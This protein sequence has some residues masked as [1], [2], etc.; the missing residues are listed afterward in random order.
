ML[1]AS[2]Y[3]ISNNGKHVELH[4]TTIHCKNK[5]VHEHDFVTAK[6][7][8]TNRVRCTTCGICYCKLCGKALQ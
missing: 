6:I 3:E 2:K 4:G 1:R 8:E 5:L 7:K